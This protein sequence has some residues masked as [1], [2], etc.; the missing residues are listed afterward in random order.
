[1]DCNSHNQKV[2]RLSLLLLLS[3]LLVYGQITRHEFITYDDLAYLTENEHLKDGIN[4]KDIKWAFTTTYLSNWHPLTWLSHMLDVQLF[5]F[6]AG[7]HHFVNVILHSINTLLLFVLLRRITGT[8]YRSVVVAALFAL[9]P[10]HVESVAWAAE[11]K[12]VL[13]TCF[14]FLTM[15]S[16]VKYAGSKSVGNYFA[17]LAFY[18]LG[19]MAKPMLVT[20]PIVL[21]LIDLWPLR[22]F[23]M[24]KTLDF[25]HERG[26]PKLL[27]EKMPFFVL[28][29]LSCLI[30]LVAQKSG[31]AISAIDVVPLSLRLEN[32]V[33]SYVE[34]LHK[35]IWP[36]NLSIFYPHPL[37]YNFYEVFLCAGLF[38]GI[39]AGA[40][41]FRQQNPYLFVG[42]FWYV[43]TLLP[44]IGLVQVGLQSMADRYTYVPLIGIFI[45]I[46]W[47]A[48]TF[49][50]LF[51]KTRLPVAIFAVLGVF[52]LGFLTYRQVGRW[53]NS[54][55][56]YSHSLAVT[57]Q[58]AVIHNNLG[59]ILLGQ[60][61]TTRAL[62]HFRTAAQIHPGDIDYINN[63]ATAL[64][65]LGNTELALRHFKLAQK[66]NPERKG[67]YYN[68]A[69]A[70]LRGGHL[71][72]AGAYLLKAVEKYPE[73]GELYH[74]LGSV[75]LIRGDIASAMA[76]F[77]QAVRLKPD[78]L[79]AHNDL[80]KSMEIWRA[81][82]LE[83][84]KLQQLIA[85][86]QSGKIKRKSIDRIH[87]QKKALDQAI[88]RYRKAISI[89]TAVMPGRSNKI[90]IKSIEKIV[91]KYTAIINEHTR[92]TSQH[93]NSS[94]K[95]NTNVSG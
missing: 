14:W 51:K 89:L 95:V 80:A 87:R 84:S 91:E 5:G 85:A 66:L 44:V 29:V 47:Q 23:T 46:S 60:G 49:L 10:L 79:A 90:Q 41:I 86:Y 72:A 64:L 77:E 74:L 8:V 28:A 39:S 62:Q 19:L 88:W 76:A 25:L 69:K 73:F 18:T 92:T 13:S 83:S 48:A 63:Y 24:S 70:M 55:S 6:N 9:H 17:A 30:T 54:Y 1:M 20:L 26:F 15:L 71:E 12:D 22:R 16:Y 7:L 40:V 56:I 33:V 32:A 58:N 3:V 59:S 45:A 37:E 65:E 35:M 53:Q 93:E 4:F 31:G 43:I 36:F 27:Y 78:Y 2:L 82:E 34:Y 68:L 21:V 81:I 67:V 52:F 94:G 75:R 38:I 50:N 11:R 42:W 57:S 61:K